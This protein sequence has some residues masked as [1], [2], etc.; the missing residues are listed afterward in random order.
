MDTILTQRRS[1]DAPADSLLNR[2]TD[3]LQGRR[4]YLVLIANDQEWTARSLASVLGAHGYAVTR[5]FTGRQAIELAQHAHPD[6]I[7]LDR[8][9]PDLDGISVCRML[10]SHPGFRASTPILITT[11]EQGVRADRLAAY[12]AGAWDFCVEPIDSEVLLRKMQVWLNARGESDALRETSLLDSATGLYNASGLARRAREI[13]AVAARMGSQMSCVA[14]AVGDQSDKDFGDEAAS[15]VA[16]LL[17]T[18]GRTSDVF[19][20]VGQSEFAVVAPATNEEGARRL[21]DR[22][23]SLIASDERTVP[24]GGF[25]SFTVRTGCA[26]SQNASMDGI[27]ALELL[28]QA[29]ASIYH[30][31]G[32]RGSEGSSAQFSD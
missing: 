6:L 28:R 26:S 31:R 20:R 22:L 19:G 25:S 1:L 7:I 21:A 23:C 29:S 27:E 5:A 13:G 16:E 14:F 8:R 4:P 10:L 24:S 9:M 12:E 3:S 18:H 11:S 15:Q 17:R 32:A 2:M 30:S